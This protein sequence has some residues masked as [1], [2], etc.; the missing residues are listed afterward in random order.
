MP[1]QSAALQSQMITSH[2]VMAD[3][4]P[5]ARSSK[6]SAL[7]LSKV[8]GKLARELDSA[9]KKSGL[10]RPTARQAE[11]MRTTAAQLQAAT[12]SVK[13]QASNLK[14]CLKP[15]L[16]TYERDIALLNKGQSPRS[17][18]QCEQERETFKTH[19]R[20]AESLVAAVLPEPEAATCHGA[21]N[22]PNQGNV[23][24]KSVAKELSSSSPGNSMLLDNAIQLINRLNDAASAMKHV[25]DSPATR[26]AVAPLST[27]RM[28]FEDLR[29]AEILRSQNW[30]AESY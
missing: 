1:V 27:D 6:E 23:P 30:G 16:I 26:A 22:G 9:S 5:H 29:Q 24:L 10:M 3:L 7:E 28:Y 20:L 19:V 18:V 12:N 21:V 17:L 13:N 4:L 25:L 8:V 2:R 15:I 14:G 11:E